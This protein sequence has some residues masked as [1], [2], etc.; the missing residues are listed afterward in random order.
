MPPVVIRDL[1]INVGTPY[2]AAVPGSP[3]GIG[4]SGATRWLCP[5]SSSSGSVNCQA[6]S[7]LGACGR[8]FAYPIAPRLPARRS[9]RAAGSLK[10]QIC[11]CLT[12]AL[13]S[14]TAL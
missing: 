7:Q 11:P 8:W 2:S 9:R 14:D 4:S 12:S 1:V 5:R 10:K 13:D 6:S 3:S